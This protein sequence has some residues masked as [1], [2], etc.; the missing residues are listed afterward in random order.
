MLKQKK[1]EAVIEELGRLRGHEL[2]AT[3][4]LELRCRVAGALAAK[5][6]HRQRMTSPT[7]QWKKPTSPRR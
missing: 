2:N 4:M 1:I 7:F 6:R 3:D 5:K